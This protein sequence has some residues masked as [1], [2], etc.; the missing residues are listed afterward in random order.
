MN[1]VLV[2]LGVLIVIV[3]LAWPWLRRIPL[4]R[5]PGDVVID[6]PGFRLFLPFT[7]MIVVSLLASLILWLLRK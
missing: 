7:T 6:R 2:A 1:R 3:G 5:L 4:F